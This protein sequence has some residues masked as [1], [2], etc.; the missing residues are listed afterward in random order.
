MRVPGSVGCVMEERGHLASKHHVAGFVNLHAFV[1]IW[2]L[3]GA[4]VC[5]ALRS[6]GWGGLRRKGPSILDFGDGGSA[7]FEFG[8]FW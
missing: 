7:S 3:G 2:C 4:I 6:R 8:E 5:P 1:Q